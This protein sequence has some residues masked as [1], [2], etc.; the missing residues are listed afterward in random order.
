MSLKSNSVMTE[1]SRIWNTLATQGAPELGI[2]EEKMRGTRPTSAAPCSMYESSMNSD[3]YWPAFPTRDARRRKPPMQEPMA[4]PMLGRDPSFHS[5]QGI[6]ATSGPYAAATNNTRVYW[7]VTIR[8]AARSPRV[9]VLSFGSFMSV[10]HEEM[11]SKPSMFQKHTLMNLPN[12]T[13]PSVFCSQTLGDIDLA[14]T[15]MNAMTGTPVVMAKA[16]SSAGTVCTETKVGKL[17]SRAT[18]MR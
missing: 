15:A 12:C 5:C 18:V 13:G 16:V 6:L 1:T 17:N 7:T 14:P 9:I 4:Q 8:S 11:L 2:L 3:R 10:V